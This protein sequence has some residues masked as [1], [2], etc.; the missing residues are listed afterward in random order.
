[1]E[2]FKWTD[3]TVQMFCRVY[4]AALGKKYAGLYEIKKYKGQ[5]FEAKVEMFKKDYLA[6]NARKREQLDTF[7]KQ[8]QIEMRQEFDLRIEKFKKQHGIKS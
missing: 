1:M 2:E 7:A 3:E 6:A 8:L 5:R 4:T